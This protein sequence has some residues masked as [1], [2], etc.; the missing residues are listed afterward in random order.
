MN[1]PTLTKEKPD[2]VLL[3]VP[4]AGIFPY[5]SPKAMYYAVPKDC[6]EMIQKKPSLAIRNGFLDL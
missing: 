6:W 1:Y 2:C 5:R 3:C 4:Q